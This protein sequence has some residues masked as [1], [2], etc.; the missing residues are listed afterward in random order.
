MAIRRIDPDAM[1]PARLILPAHTPMPRRGGWLTDE[2]FAFLNERYP[3]FTSSQVTNTV[4]QFLSETSVA[5]FKS[6]PSRESE[7]NHQGLILVCFQHHVF[8]SVCSHTKQKLRTWFGNQNRDGTTKRGGA[9]HKLDL[10]GRANRRPNPLQPS[11]AYSSLYYLKGSPVFI[12]I[13]E[14]YRL[15]RSGDTATLSRYQHL[16]ATKSAT[17]GEEVSSTAEDTSPTAEEASTTEE[18]SSNNSEP[19]SPG[20]PPFVHFQQTLFREKV[21]TMSTHE[22]AAVATYIEE[23]HIAAVEAWE[24]PWMTMPRS[25]KLPKGLKAAPSKSPLT[26]EELEMEFYQK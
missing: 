19:T 17:P 2:E 5:F 26:H 6:F 16:F 14:L 24:R 8:A 1:C 9:R 21:K 20:L 10:S 12:E 22:A 18:S 3:R 11:Q 13:T 23:Q 25:S 4:G 7:L 15:Y